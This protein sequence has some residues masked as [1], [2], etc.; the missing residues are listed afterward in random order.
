MKKIFCAALC[1]M[2]FM[3]CGSAGAQ[4]R[5]KLSRI[6]FIGASSP[7]TAGSWLEAFRR[8]LRDLGYIEGKNITIEIRWAEGSA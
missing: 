4:Q 2:L 1:A 7:S 6:G 5:A 3:L 8:G